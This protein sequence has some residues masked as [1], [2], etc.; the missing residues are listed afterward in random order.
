MVSLKC[1]QCSTLVTGAPGAQV[2]CPNCGFEGEVPRS[3]GPLLVQPPRPA[4]K[5][6]IGRP[7]STPPARPSGPEVPALQ[8][9]GVWAYLL[10]I[11]SLGTFFLGRFGLP[12]FLGLAAIGLGLSTYSKN[13]QDKR[14]MI[15]VIIGIAGLLAGV[16]YLVVA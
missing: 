16:V 2:R 7:R 8:N 11:L 9:Q 15:A 6:I 14:S 1:P 5:H 10:A 3:G 12:F 13:R 4:P